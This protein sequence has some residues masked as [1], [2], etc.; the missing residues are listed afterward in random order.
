MFDIPEYTAPGHIQAASIAS[1]EAQVLT[2][3]KVVRLL[4][5]FI[6]FVD[7][8][9]NDC[10]SGFGQWITDCG[11]NWGSLTYMPTESNSVDMVDELALLLTGG[12][13]SSSSREILSS[14]ADSEDS[15]SDGLRLAQKLILVTPEFQ[16]NSIFYSTS[17][18]R[19]EAENPSSSGR[20]YKAVRRPSL[21]AIETVSTL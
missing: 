20:R 10:F 11:D 15:F 8:G 1:P 17:A 9:L 5:G 6:S 19:P 14:A 4:N 18:D 21:Y 16:S 3:P 7:W 12:R 13:L 2:G